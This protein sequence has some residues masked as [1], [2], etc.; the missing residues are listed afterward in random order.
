[1]QKSIIIVAVVVII[2]AAGGFYGGM[3]YAQGNSGA[4]G[5]FANLTPAQRQARMQQFGAAGGG[6]RGGAGGG[7]SGQVIA[8]D[9]K[10]VT[11]K[12]RSGSTQIVFYSPST[13]V[14]KT[15]SGAL[16]DL[17]V[18][19]EITAA[20]TP[21]SDGSLSAQ[22]IQIRPAPPASTSTTNPANQ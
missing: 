17:A 2:A 21:N 9:D 6:G 4:T 22:S 11:V 7:A 12:L 15:V 13:S 14:G 20:G 8:M 3:K 16:A 1:M 10:S 18:G 5:N 19:Q